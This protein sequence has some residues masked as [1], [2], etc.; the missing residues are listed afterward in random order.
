LQL[1]D[2]IAAKENELICNGQWDELIK[3]WD[4]RDARRERTHNE[5]K[6]SLD[7]TI[8]DKAVPD[9]EDLL[10]LEKI[11][12][13]CNKNICDNE[14]INYDYKNIDEYVSSPQLAKA[15]K[16]LTD[17]QKLV[18]YLYSIK[19]YKTSEIAEI[20]NISP[21]GVRNHLDSAKRN[22]FKSLG[23]ELTVVA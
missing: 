5:H 10:D 12:Q 19:Q 4:D 22:I 13:I 3:M 21:R 17:K 2:R 18:L 15:L 9:E 1:K 8:M 7:L 6:D 23:I 16:K 20:I 14:S 11:Y